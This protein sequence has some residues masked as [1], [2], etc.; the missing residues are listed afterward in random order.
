MKNRRM[1]CVAFPGIVLGVSG[2]GSG[3]SGSGDGSVT[4]AFAPTLIDAAYAMETLPFQAGTLISSTI[5]GVDVSVRLN[6][7]AGLSIPVDGAA[8]LNSEV[9]PI[10][11]DSGGR[12]SSIAAPRGAFVS[13]E[14]RSVFL[15]ISNL[16]V[17]RS[18]ADGGKFTSARGL[19]MLNERMYAGD[20]SSESALSALSGVQELPDKIA[21]TGLALATKE[22]DRMLE[23]VSRIFG[24][25]NAHA[26]EATD[27]WNTLSN[28][29]LIV[30]DFIR[31]YPG[32]SINIGVFVAAAVVCPFVPGV[33]CTVVL[34]V[35]AF[36][37]LANIAAIAKAKNTGLTVK[38]NFGGDDSGGFSV[39]LSQ[40][41][42]ASGTLYSSQDKKNYSVE[43]SF[44]P[45]GAVSLSTTGM[46]GT[47][48]SF[49]GSLAGTVVTG[50][51]INSRAQEKG[52]FRGIVSG[53]V[54]GLS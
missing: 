17:V 9:F 49:K 4:Q 50:T 51:W 33:G 10:K 53:N 45:D 41:G 37:A 26:Q 24:I 1:F 13:F 52:T 36:M 5:S 28:P 54:K 18:Y 42:S 12:L 15:G 25:S 20:F 3:T 34:A 6:S 21:F 47:G 27:G 44:S 2:C 48:A 22:M 43:G 40:N 30:N 46:A 35:L 16:I 23:I 11:F 29:R 39:K 14:Y 38:G 31:N 8:A 7:V 19:Y 32:T